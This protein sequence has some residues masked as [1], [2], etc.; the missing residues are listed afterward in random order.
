MRLVC[1]NCKANYEIPP[2][3][4]PI[5]GRE[6]KCD[7]CGHSWFQTRHKK[8]KEKKLTKPD[9]KI[10]NEDIIEVE[11][12]ESNK[13]KIDPSVI[14]ILKEEA[15]REIEARDRERTQKNISSKSK[16]SAKNVG[17]KEP[18]T[19]TREAILKHQSKDAL[20]E[21]LKDKKSTLSFGFIFGLLLVLF[22]LLAYLFGEQLIMV[23]PEA[24]IYF[25]SYIGLID[26]IR[27]ELNKLAGR[28][29]FLLTNLI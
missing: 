10:A 16:K 29:T 3:A 25:V 14:K 6:V 12:S 19:L 7:S 22:A 8:T 13:K 20:A 24:E 17:D 21:A 4:V 27:L 5:G 26:E 2:N 9:I 28:V 18:T 23:F 1:P 11:S 15:K